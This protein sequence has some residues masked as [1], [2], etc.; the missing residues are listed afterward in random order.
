MTCARIGP[1]GDHELKR[2][3]AGIR[4]WNRSERGGGDGPGPLLAKSGDSP[5]AGPSGKQVV[6]YPV[7]APD[8][9]GDARLLAQGLELHRWDGR[10]QDELDW[11]V[12]VSIKGKT[13]GK[14]AGVNEQLVYLVNVGLQC[15]FQENQGAVIDDDRIADKVAALAPRWP[16][17]LPLGATGG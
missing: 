10:Q 6:G 8:Q 5:V 1:F 11:P 3:R 9:E 13:M 12:A 7:G 4:A 15:P 14:Q 17:N 2:P 16:G